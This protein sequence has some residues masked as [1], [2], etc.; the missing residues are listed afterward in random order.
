MKSRSPYVANTSTQN[1]TFGSIAAGRG[2]GSTAKASDLIIA[3]SKH[4]LPSKLMAGRV[5]KRNPIGL[6]WANLGVANQVIH[7]FAANFPFFIGNFLP[8][9][10]KANL[11]GYSLA[12]ISSTEL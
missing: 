4:K 7:F 3:R 11:D 10:N 6:F 8:R 5:L 2:N 12:L 1:L 9:L